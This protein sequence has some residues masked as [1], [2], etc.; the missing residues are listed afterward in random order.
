MEL[1]QIL[2]IVWKWAWLAVLAVVIGAT[3]SYFASMAS[4]PLYRTSTTL[5]IGAVIQNP[6]PNSVQ[7]YTS[8]Q[9][10]Y[11]YIQLA[12]RENV[13]NGAIKALGLK[14]D[15]SAL[16]SQV[17]ANNIPNTQLLTITVVDADPY[18]AKVLADEI[19]NQLIQQGPAASGDAGPDQTIFAQ[20]Q[21]DDLQS[22]ITTG[23]QDLNKL[24]QD[25]DTANSARQIQDLQTQVSVLETKISNWQNTYASLLLSFK[26]G[27]SNSLA[28][29]EPAPI[30]SVPFSPN[31]R[32]NM[33]V[34]AVIG[35]VLSVLGVVLIEYFDDTLKTPDDFTRITGLP[36]LGAIA[37]IDGNDYPDKLL[38]L[39]QPLSPI[40]EAYRILRTNLQFSSI[41]QPLQTL[42]LTSPGPAEG[43]S[44]TLAN[45]A[46]VLAQSGRK[47][48]VVDA[49]LRRPVQH[50]I[51][52]VS[53][54]LGLTDALL[55]AV[56]SSLLAGEVDPAKESTPDHVKVLLETLKSPVVPPDHLRPDAKASET[57][58]PVTKFIQ[59]TGV[60]NLRLLSTGSLPPNPAEL[61]SSER[62]GRLLELL[63]VEADM[64]LV[65]SPPILLVTDAVI[66]GSRVDGTIMVIDSGRTRVAEVR[67]AVD[68]LRKGHINVV[69][70]VMNRMT[71]H[72]GG[73]YYYY[74]H[75]YDSD[76][77]RSQRRKK[78]HTR[79]F[80]KLLA[81]LPR[82]SN[83]RE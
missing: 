30:P 72:S 75:Y 83:H 12:S 2:N 53:N 8:Q 56:P 24:T 76:G 74:H 45:L 7:I 65:D 79:F 4:T 11:T 10:A 26:G 40:V 39:T 38:A 42:I 25:L 41:D 71:R 49:D 77:N 21:L 37:R 18:R 70:G 13:L 81:F 29:E 48:I 14:M 44:I 28:V 46:V 31:T 9:L 33:L 58:Q 59:T 32:Q 60:E 17:S 35:L 36:A 62:M 61:M 5:M 80:D 52:G 57:L 1:R 50:K 82:G 22:K 69:G 6:D 51:F 16:A 63:K 78:K 67:R 68:D 19:A 73:Y 20:K 27:G 66:L 54:R 34:A 23:Q 43:K 15:W 47:V 64:V 55:H 3:T